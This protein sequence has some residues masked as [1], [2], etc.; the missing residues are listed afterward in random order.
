MSPNKINLKK[1]LNSKWT[2]VEPAEKERHFMV[3]EVE[4]D[5]QGNVVLIRPDQDVPLGAKL[6]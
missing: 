6:Y 4:F 2:A 3:T 5:E 1:L